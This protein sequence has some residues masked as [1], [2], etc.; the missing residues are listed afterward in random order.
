M[1]TYAI[2]SA[3]PLRIDRLIRELKED[4]REISEDPHDIMDYLETRGVNVEGFD[5][6]ISEELESYSILRYGNR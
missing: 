3:W 4:Y 1:S 2:H 5:L 6:I